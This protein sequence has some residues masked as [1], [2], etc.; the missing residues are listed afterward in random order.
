MSKVNLKWIFQLATSISDENTLQYYTNLCTMDEDDPN[1]N[2][3][4]NNFFN[5]VIYVILDEYFNLKDENL[6]KFYQLNISH[7]NLDM[8]DVDDFDAVIKSKDKYMID[9]YKSEMFNLYFKRNIYY[10]LVNDNLWFFKQLSYRLF[11]KY[12]Y[13]D[14]VN[15]NFIGTVEQ[16]TRKDFLIKIKDDAYNSSKNQ[17]TKQTTSND[18][19]EYSV[20][21]KARPYKQKKRF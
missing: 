15:N 1:L 8:L 18:D 5:D 12:D 17:K 13:F 2:E 20:I 7:G 3:I 21:C 16:K 9:K 11:D 10:N 19:D 6:V 14:N 4:Y